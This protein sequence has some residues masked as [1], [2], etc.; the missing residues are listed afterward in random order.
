MCSFMGRSQPGALATST[1]CEDSPPGTAPRTTHPG[2]R[3]QACRS[4]HDWIGDTDPNLTIA[5][6]RLHRGLST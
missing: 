2:G 3:Q 1:S 4:I 5:T 6:V